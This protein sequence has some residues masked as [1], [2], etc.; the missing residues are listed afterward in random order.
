MHTSTALLFLLIQ[1]FVADFRKSF[2]ITLML[3]LT[4]SAVLSTSASRPEFEFWSASRIARELPPLIEAAYV[5]TDDDELRLDPPPGMLRWMLSP[6]GMRD[7]LQV[8]IGVRGEAQLI[9][10]VAAVPSA[11]RLRGERH[12]AA[13]EVS[14]LCL[15]RQWRGQGLTRVLLEELRRRCDA[16]GVQLAVY[17]ASRPRRVRPLLRAACFHRPLLAKALLESAFLRAEATDNA[18]DPNESAAAKEQTRIT[19]ADVRK[20][21]YKAARLPQPLRRTPSSPRLRRMRADDALE[22]LALS[23]EHARAFA[24]A[25]SFSMAQFRHRFLGCGAISLVLRGRPRHSRHRCL[26]WRRRSHLQGS[27]G[28][29]GSGGAD[30]GGGGPLLGF[31]SFT[32]L[33]LRSASGKRLVQAQLLGLALTPGAPTEETL[34]RLVD[35]ALRT[36]RREGAA[37]FNALA[38]GDLSP[39]RLA[40]LG[41]V[42]GDGETFVHV[43]HSSAVDA[44]DEPQTIDPSAVSWTPMLS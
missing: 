44:A 19:A 37:V 3:F 11:L 36:A 9:G 12:Q 22:C 15:R 40:A 38:V 42:Q 41:F 39:A 26:F 16:A 23:D 29:H 24:L 33:P 14:L 13:V 30:A 7:E 31:I 27:G 1:S 34:E 2:V 21:L 10:F 17:T 4:L 18:A 8:G 25:H 28:G 6:P 35:G 20:A 5:A 32:L 43:E